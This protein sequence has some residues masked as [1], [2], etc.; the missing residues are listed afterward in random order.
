MVGVRRAGVTDVAGELQRESIIE[1]ARAHIRV[2][3]VVRLGEVSCECY[4]L[5][6]DEYARVFEPPPEAL[7]DDATAAG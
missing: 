5:I 4:E 7:S 3:D 2:L 1:Y 6:R